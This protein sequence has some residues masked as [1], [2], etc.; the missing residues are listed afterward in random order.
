MNKKLLAGLAI[1]PLLALLAA[2]ASTPASGSTASKVVTVKIGTTDASAD[3]W[4]ILEKAAKAKGINIETVNFSDYNQANPALAQKQI[5]LSLF[6]HLQF[7]GTYNVAANQNLTPIGATMI[8]PLGLYSQKY[9]SL[10]AIPKGSTIAVPNDPANLARGLNVLKSA[11]LIKFNGNPSQP[12]Q[13]DID[14][15]KS[16]VTVTLVDASQT[17]AS[18]PSV[19][20]AIINNNFVQDAKIDPKSVLY[21]D[22]PS[23]PAAQ[24]YI[25]TFVSRAADKNNPTFAEIVKLYHTKPVLDA[26]EASSKGTGVVVKGVSNAELASILAKVEKNIRASE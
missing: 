8:V 14:T 7:L 12:T 26:V 3:Y 11:G 25:N 24:P 13:A 4:P 1:V 20:G 22:N 18:L 9:K 21:Q 19:A 17:V 15:A 10:S 5:D 2:C 16:K 23:S 6:E